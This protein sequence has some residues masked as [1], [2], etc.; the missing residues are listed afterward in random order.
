M[1]KVLQ[2][3]NHMYPHLGG[4]E[5]LTRDLADVL[6]DQNVE[7]KILCLN[8]T[9]SDGVYHCNRA[10]TVHDIIDGVE[11]IR[12]GCVAKVRSQ[13]LSLTFSRELRCLMD[14]FQPD[15]IIFHY[16]N[17]FE[18]HF[19][20][21]YRKRKCKLIVY[22]HLDIT[23]QKV[24]GKLFQGQTEA[25]LKRADRVVATSPNYVEGSAFLRSVREKC[26]VIPSCIDPERLVLSP[27]AE[28]TAKQIRAETGDR[29][30]CFAVGRHVPYKGLIYLIRAATL[31]DDHFRILIGGAGPLTEALKKAAADD[32]KIRFTGRLSDEELI[33]CY[34][35]CDIFCFPS[36][37]KNEAFGLALAEAMYFGKPAVTFTIPGSGVNY[38]SVDRETGLECPNQD[39]TLYA[40]ALEKLACDPQLRERLGQNA[41]ERVMENFTKGQFRRNIERLLESL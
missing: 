36:I 1:K 16:P 19:L 39:A 23:R 17:P 2:I 11:V 9:A 38:V 3:T 22:W 41:H 8:E 31:L 10:E 6:C 25:L 35:A 20:L 21:H 4:I 15:I 12:C 14:N 40:A 33:A 26:V 30:L 29:V 24:L 13:G 7:Q 28:R 34:S 5:R 37:T 18:A 27:D 32:E